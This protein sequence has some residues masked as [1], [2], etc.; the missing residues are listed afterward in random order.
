MNTHEYL[1]EKVLAQFE[2]MLHEEYKISN[3]YISLKAETL[4]FNNLF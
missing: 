4:K 3:N 2:C 1:T